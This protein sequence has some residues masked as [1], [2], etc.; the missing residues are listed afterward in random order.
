MEKTIGELSTSELTELIDHAID[1]R[2][3]VW[4][5]QI[6]DALTDAKAEDEAELQPE[7][8][9]SLRRSLVH[10]RAGETLDLKIF[11][12]QLGR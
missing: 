11:R 3:M 9:D 7:F 4:L 2:L 5:T 1:K 6:T 8:A 12:E 10:A